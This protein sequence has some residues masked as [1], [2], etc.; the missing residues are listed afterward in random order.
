MK[1]S[2]PSRFLTAVAGSTSSKFASDIVIS[3]GLAFVNGV[4]PVDIA[5]NKA[6]L[7]EMVEAQTTRIFANLDTILAVAELN[8][9]NLVSVHVRL[10]DYERLVDRMN[11]AYSRCMGTAELPTRSC[12]GVARLNRGALVEMDFVVRVPS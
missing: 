2:A 10:V 5:N 8:G 9:R 12:S 6:A 3:G 4:C 1:Q 7:P 11:V